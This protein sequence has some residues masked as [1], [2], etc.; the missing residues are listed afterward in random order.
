MADAQ[1]V[2]V[3]AVQAAPVFLDAA[4]TVEVAVDR[5]E[6]AAAAG[7]RLVA[8]GEGFLPGHPI[9]LHVH[10]VTSPA[11]IA[12]AGALVRSAITIPGPETDRLAEVARQTGTMVVMGV[13]ERI[14]PGRSELALTALVI[15]PDGRVSHRRKLVP[16]VG[17]RVLFTPAAGDSIRVF[18]SP[19]GP[20][21]VLLGGENSNP[22]L[23]WTLRELGAR[24][25]VAAWPPHFNKP[26]VMGET[27]SI[28]GR[29]IAYQNS[30]H[31]ISVAGATTPETRDRI[32][33]DGE[34]RA[35]LDAMAVDPASTIYAPRGALLAG[36]LDGG[37]GILTADLDLG[38][39]AWPSLVNRQYDRPD[40]FHVRIDGTARGTPLAWADARGD[41]T[42]AVPPA[43]PADDD[44]DERAR[45]AIAERYGDVLDADDAERLVPFVAAVLRTS[46][47]LEAIDPP[48]DPA[49]GPFAED[50]RPDR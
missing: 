24:I 1:T 18:P 40:L 30:A 29:A 26:G 25:H 13:V 49:D 17:E 27:A 6:Q 48:T 44:L 20:I 46:A 41:A 38:A 14:D 28:T 37:D 50:R 8:F 9:W 45:R 34:A 33:R 15:D 36:P 10:P 22:L 35:L 31:V 4:A 23:T 32:A 21:S 12:L 42:T 39:G 5:I 7:A 2:R 43:P 19:W 47:R 3:A 16:A 11:Q